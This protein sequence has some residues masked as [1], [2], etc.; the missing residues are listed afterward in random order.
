M[1]KKLS[2]LSLVAL[3]SACSI[4][5]YVPFMGDKKPAFAQLDKDQIDQK[6]YAAGY[7]ATAQT[8]KG[9]LKADYDINS[10]ASGANDWNQ[11]RILVSLEQIRAK[12][13]QGID[14]NIHAYYSG[15]IFASELQN[16]FNRLNAQ[17]WNKINRPSLTLG[18]YDAMAD[19]QKGKPR[20]ENDEYIV[21]GNDEL[22]ATCK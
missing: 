20:A 22:L 5:S 16:N 19:V 7:A 21:K 8:Y 11:G 13:S 10:F 4:S 9:Q 18:I 14:S 2:L 12:L 15:V 17:C 1:L 6:S 3:L